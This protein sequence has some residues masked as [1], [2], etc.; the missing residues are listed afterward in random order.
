[1]EPTL[2]A[3]EVHMRL[4]VMQRAHWNNRRYF[5]GVVCQRVGQHITQQA[6]RG[7]DRN[8]VP[9]SLL[10]GEL[11]DFDRASSDAAQ[12]LIEAIGRLEELSPRPAEVLWLRDVNGLS[13][14]QAVHVLD[15]SR[16]TVQNAWSIA[17]AWLLG[18]L[19][20][21]VHSKTPSMPS[22]APTP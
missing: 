12:R 14:E 4:G 11:P 22:R 21:D 17:R 6:K 18:E 8:R 5:F 13:I 1:L 9:C 10:A 15:S 19:G 7:G 2:I 3:D 16:R 20:D